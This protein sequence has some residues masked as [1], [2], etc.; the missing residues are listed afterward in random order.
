LVEHDS[1]NDFIQSIHSRNIFYLTRH[2]STTPDNI[3]FNNKTIY[4]IFG[5]ESS[6]I[7]KTILK[8]N[9]TRTIRIPTSGN[10]RSL[11]LSNCVAILGYEYAKQNKYQ[12]LSLTEPH[13][14]VLN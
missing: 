4:F 3:A 12:G 14:N 10:V 13:G 8:K 6:G 7:P 1:Y 11:N 9:K 5:K 2:G